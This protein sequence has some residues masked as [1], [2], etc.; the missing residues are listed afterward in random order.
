MSDYI[1][2]QQPSSLAFLGEVA[3]ATVETVT[4]LLEIETFTRIGNRFFNV[5]KVNDYNESIEHMKR[6]GCF[7]EI[8]NRT[9]KFGDIIKD[10]QIKFVINKGDE[11]GYI[12]NV[13][14]QERSLSLT[15]P[16]YVK[17]ETSA[18]LSKVLLIDIDFFTMKPVDCSIVKSSELVHKN[19][20]EI[21]HLI[22][23]L[24]N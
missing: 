6:L 11:K 19:G 10:P 13:G 7:E 1:T 5:L 22:S 17:Y 4:H 15:L 23:A 16:K 20:R 21:K 18:F 8:R 24:F 14:H 2:Q 12:V 3:D 9:A